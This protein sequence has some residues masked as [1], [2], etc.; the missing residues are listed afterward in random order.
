MTLD[1]RRPR[2]EGAGSTL[3][4]LEG[5][6]IVTCSEDGCDHPKKASGVCNACYQRHWKAGTLPKRTKK[7][8][9]SPH[10][11]TVHPPSRACY[12]AHRCRCDGCRDS[13]VTYETRRTRQ[14]AYGKPTMVD[15]QPVLEHVLMLSEAGLG[16]VR[17]AQLTGLSPSSIE[18]LKRG[19]KRVRKETADAIMAVEPWQAERTPKKL[20]QLGKNPKCIECEREPLF[21]GLRCL[22][23]FQA[24]VR[25]NRGEH[26][27][28]KHLPSI[29][30]YQR[31]RCRCRDCKDIVRDERKASRHR[32]QQRDAA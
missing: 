25:A 23:H 11:C 2:R 18:K 27:C 21:G 7:R 32:S 29:H 4:E 10:T 15:A 24:K 12:S 1:M 9:G 28:L 17:L 20:A 30:C 14:A 26:G 19:S 31:C 13:N 3:P 22:R 5:P 6:A 8:D 16:K